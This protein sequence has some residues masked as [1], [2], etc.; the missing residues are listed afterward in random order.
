MIR[1][2][3]TVLRGI[4]H[5]LRVQHRKVLTLL[6][7]VTVYFTFSVL[8]SRFMLGPDDTVG[9][10]SPPP[11]ELRTIGQAN[12]NRERESTVLPAFLP[13]RSRIDPETYAQVKFGDWC[14]TMNEK[15]FTH[16][17]ALP[18]AELKA[19][20]CHKRLP[21]VIIIGVKKCGTGSL[22]HFLSFHPSVAMKHN[23]SI[24]LHF[25]DLHQSKGYNWY[26]N[27]LLYTTSHQLVVEKSPQYLTWPHDCA[28]KVH[29]Y[30]SRKTKIIV[31]LCDPVRRAISDFVFSTVL[32]PK[33]DPRRRRHYNLA[34]TFEKSV[35]DN[36][37]SGQS[38]NFYN[39]M[40]D[41]GIYVKHILRWLEYFPRDQFYVLDGGR[42][43]Q[44]PYNEV[45][46]VEKFLGLP[47]FV[48][49]DHFYFDEVK[50]FYCMAFPYRHCLGDTKGLSHPEVD[51]DVMDKLYEFYR[52]YDNLL[53]E[54]FNQTFS[55]MSAYEL[56]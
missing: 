12:A 35:I 40:I 54:M 37:F 26:R 49:R 42:L 4:R 27:Q 30:V 28:K 16:E 31:V 46:K 7:I 15:T 10:Y 1:R 3:G 29:D 34:K 36:E 5:H 13:H 9:F 2:R 44:D 6:V 51:E 22:V 43:K 41:T 17:R 23:D 8:S 39:E 20:G 38:V 11:G 21:D 18:A 56:L 52:P 50:R 25:F 33:A 24:E 53:S 55:W 32:R 14:Y 48:T 19:K 47:E 45:R